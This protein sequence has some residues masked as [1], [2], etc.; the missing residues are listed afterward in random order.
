MRSFCLKNL[1][2]HP[3]LIT[4]KAPVSSTPCA[5]MEIEPKVQAEQ[6]TLDFG[7]CNLFKLEKVTPSYKEGEE[8]YWLFEHEEAFPVFS[9]IKD[10]KRIFVRHNLA[11]I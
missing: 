8:P 5:F 1:L 7:E 6:S 2:N 3:K 9:T 4:F 10:E 11:S